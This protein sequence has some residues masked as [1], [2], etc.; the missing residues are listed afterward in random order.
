MYRN[1]T[2]WWTVSAPDQYP[3][4]CYRWPYKVCEFYCSTDNL[5]EAL[6]VEELERELGDATCCVYTGDSVKVIEKRLTNQRKRVS[7]IRLLTNPNDCITVGDQTF[8][9]FRHI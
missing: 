1:P 9:R 4:E 8:P 6:D 3:R 2:N 5:N 7:G